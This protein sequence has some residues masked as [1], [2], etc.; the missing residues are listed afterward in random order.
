MTENK[1]IVVTD[2][3]SLFNSILAEAKNNKNKDHEGKME[4]D[5]GTAAESCLRACIRLEYSIDYCEEFAREHCLR[6]LTSRERW[7]LK[8]CA[9]RKEIKACGKTTFFCDIEEFF[10]PLLDLFT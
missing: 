5:P 7:R 2:Y 10:A 9:K 4:F 8:Y 6:G 3:E 1:K